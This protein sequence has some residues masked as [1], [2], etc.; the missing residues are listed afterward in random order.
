MDKIPELIA[1]NKNCKTDSLAKFIS[2]NNKGYPSLNAL[3]KTP[4]IVLSPEGESGSPA[5]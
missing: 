2:S 1:S 5:I 4:S 3:R